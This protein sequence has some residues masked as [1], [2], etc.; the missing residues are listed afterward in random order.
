[1]FI[2]PPLDVPAPLYNQEGPDFYAS[3]YLHNSGFTEANPYAGNPSS[4]GPYQTPLTSGQET[5]FE[6]WVAHYT[7]PFDPTAAIVDYDMRGYW[8]ANGGT[9]TTPVY[10]TGTHFP[11]TWK[12]PYDTSFSNESQYATG[13]CPFEWNDS[14]QLIDTKTGLLVFDET[15][16]VAAF[17][18][19]PF[20]E[21]D[22]WYVQ[23][24]YGRQGATAYFVLHDEFLISASLPHETN[25][26]LVTKPMSQI[27]FTDP[28]IDVILFAGLLTDPTF[29]FLAATLAE[30]QLN[31]RDWTYY[32]DT[33]LV[34]ASYLN[35]TVKYMVADMVNNSNTG[36]TPDPDMPDGPVVNAVQFDHVALSDS[37]DQL[38]QL[39]SWQSDY[40]FW[41]G[42]DLILHWGNELDSPVSGVTVTDAVTTSPTSTLAFID[43]AQQFTY[44]WD[45]T[46]LRNSC[47]VRGASKSQSQTDMWG[48]DGTTT[49]FPLS[50]DLDQSGALT[51]TVGGVGKT[52]SVSSDPPTATTQF[53][54]IQAPNGQWFLALGTSGVV[55]SGQAVSL[56]YTASI[57]ITGKYTNP[58]SV[59][60]FDG[61]NGG[62]YEIFLADNTILTSQVAYSRARSEVQQFGDV[63]ERFTFS[64]AEN[65]PGHLRTGDAFYANMAY[66]PDSRNNWIVGI[67]DYYIVVQNTINGVQ[68]G[69]RRYDIVAVRFSPNS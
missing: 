49:S 25:L 46:T 22:T 5:T 21:N 66:L 18:A 36:L 14:N 54:L 59:A 56:T 67:D 1:L 19:S 44:E 45:G 55:G 47:T 26:T 50:Y 35:K 29:V 12:T 60:Q 64:I 61:P 4:K 40:A 37:I 27:V 6:S 23:E 69:R 20:L 32:S 51:L 58:E 10:T 68:G 38:S 39:A 30:Y 31:C 9:G 52:I 2:T 7:V 15:S 62:V 53:V 13:S 17:D 57:P 43:L 65:W 63:L 8:L 11:D 42:Y 41:V 33:R 16:D 24:E 34:T 48:G 3:A 28:D